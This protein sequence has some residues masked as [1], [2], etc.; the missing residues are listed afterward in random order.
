[1]KNVSIKKLVCGLLGVILG[2]IIGTLTPPAELTAESMRY[3]GLLVWFI[4][5]MVGGVMP[6]FMTGLAFLVLAVLFKLTDFTSAFSPF[7]G[8]TTWL[9]VGAFGVGA[10]LSKTG[11]LKRIAYVI[12]QIFPGTYT[13]QMLALYTAGIIV[14]PMMPSITA[15]AALMTPLSI[16][17]AEAFGFEKNSKGATGLFLSSYWSA[18]ILG[19]FFFTG[20]VY[21][22]TMMAYLDDETLALLNFWS[23][24]KFFWPFLLVFAV[25]G[26]FLIRLLYQPKD[27]QPLPQGF[28]KE[29]LKELG[30]MSRDEKLSLIILAIMVA[31]WLTASLTGISVTMSVRHRPYSDGRIRHLQAGRFRRTYPLDDNRSRCLHLHSGLPHGHL[32]HSRMAH[33]RSRSRA[34]PRCLQPGPCSSSLSALS[35]SHSAGASHPCSPPAR[36]SMRSLPVSVQRLA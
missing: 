5:W 8:T 31:G 13:G 25:G 16:P 11:V 35:C 2:L 26:F 3:L 29:K 36:S 19:N 17:A 27:C 33:Q 9:L 10:M 23:W 14:S 1:M 7:A 28:V 4:C 24:L 22:G 34:W 12:M 32:W 18:G 6:D 15:K 30:P 20:C 21:V